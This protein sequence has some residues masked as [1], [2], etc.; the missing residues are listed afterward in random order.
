MV[1]KVKLSLPAK[2]QCQQNLYSSSKYL[3]GSS[4]EINAFKKEIGGERHF[5]KLSSIFKNDTETPYFN[6][7]SVLFKIILRVL[8][9]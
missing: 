4:S 9:P 8:F 5:F 7:L 2:F 1:L 6:W 3:Q